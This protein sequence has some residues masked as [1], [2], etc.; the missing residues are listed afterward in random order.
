M[1]RSGTF[2]IETPTDALQ[3]SQLSNLSRSWSYNPAGGAGTWRHYAE[4]VLS[5]STDV[6]AGQR[7]WLNAVCAMVNASKPMCVVVADA[8]GNSQIF[9]VSVIDGDPGVQ[10]LQYTSATSPTPSWQVGSSQLFVAFS[11]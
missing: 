11:A 6:S 5:I 7:A 9:T 4:G 2:V 3:N 8:N 10:Y 1:N